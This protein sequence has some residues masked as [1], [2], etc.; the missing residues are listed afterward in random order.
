MTASDEEIVAWI[1]EVRAGGYPSLDD[2][3]FKDLDDMDIAHIIDIMGTLFQNDRTEDSEGVSASYPADF[4]VRFM[5]DGGSN[6]KLGKVGDFST[7]PITTCPKGVNCSL[8]FRKNKR[9][10]GS[11]LCYAVGAIRSYAVGNTYTWLRNTFITY[12]SQFVGI[13]DNEIKRSGIKCV[14]ISVGGDLYSAKYVQDLFEIARRNP[15]VIFYTYTKFDRAYEGKPSNFYLN[16]SMDMFRGPPEA[17]PKQYDNVTCVVPEFITN[18]RGH[19][20]CPNQVTEHKWG[21]QSIDPSSTST[22][23]E[24]RYNANADPSKII[25][26]FQCQHCFKPLG[27]VIYF[28]FHHPFVLLSKEERAKWDTYEKLLSPPLA[29]NP[30]LHPEDAL[31]ILAWIEDNPR[32]SEKMGWTPESLWG[33]YFDLDTIRVTIEEL[34]QDLASAERK[35]IP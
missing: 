18:R 7:F 20:N 13:L 34:E 8:H 14:R 11:S 33:Q 4:R 35:V 9:V 21:G 15:E 25:T 6:S 22:R 17:V 30:K 3:M 32:A 12:H 10:K 24:K 5:N 28:R 23:G 29:V 26:C 1:K 19:I 31:E 16:M 2:P 27:L